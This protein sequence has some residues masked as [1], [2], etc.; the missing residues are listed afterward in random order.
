MKLE[1]YLFILPREVN[2]EQMPIMLEMISVV[3]QNVTVSKQ[4][5]CFG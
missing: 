1:H 4:L 5:L 2:C 3:D